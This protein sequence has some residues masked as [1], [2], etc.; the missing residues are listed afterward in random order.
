MLLCLRT[1]HGS[2]L[3]RKKSPTS[4]AKYPR[5]FTIWSQPTFSVTILPITHAT[6]QT[7]PLFPWLYFS[8]VVQVHLSLV[9]PHHSPHPR[10]L[11]S[12]LTP[13]GFVY[14][15]WFTHVPFP[16]L[17][18][19]LTSL[20]IFNTRTSE[21]S[22]GASPDAGRS[23]CVKGQILLFICLFHWSLG[24]QGGPASETPLTSSILGS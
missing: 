19:D 12:I 14:V 11:P 5:P 6:S 3:L 17:L 23:T 8:I 21:D 20:P 24:T 15:S 22:L 2:S 9:S 13:C 4:L 16:W 1:L 10:L 7:L 18:I